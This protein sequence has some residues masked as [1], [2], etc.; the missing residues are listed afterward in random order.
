[1]KI[2]L[3][4]LD[5]K[6]EDKT[7]NFNKVKSLVEKINDD[8]PDLIVLPELFS[9]GYTMNSMA[10]AENLNGETPSFL[11]KLAREH[12][13]NV[14][15]SFIE[16]AGPKPKN[17]A[18]LFDRK[19]RQLLH[20]SKIHLPSFLEEDKNYT[21]GNEIPICELDRQKIGVFI[22][23]DLRFPEIF[24]RM[25]GDVGCIF[26]IA[27]WPT[28]RVEHWDSLLK[29]RAIEN[30]SYIIGVN[31]VG[32]SPSSNYPGHSV[33]IDPLGS[34]IAYAKENEEDVVM[35]EIDFSIVKSIREKFPFLQDRVSLD[36]LIYRR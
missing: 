10:L 22:C 2:A 21:A 13:V 4:Q 29:A 3:L 6:W 18:I 32:E 35:G 1:M 19:G 25:A 30:Q 20:Y 28:E 23:Y 34:R 33:I 5:I 14:L 24:R 12:Q 9:T 31:R 8:K 15:G 36:S 16:I 26:V 7:G 17:S 11:S 27:N